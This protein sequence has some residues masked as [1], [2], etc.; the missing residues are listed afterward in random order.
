M[1]ILV[2]L[3]FLAIGL[4]LLYLGYLQQQKRRQELSSLAIQLGW[5]FDSSH[6]SSHEDR[7]PQFNIFRRGHS[8]YAY[9][10]LRG[11]FEIAEK[12]WPVVMG[13]YHYRITSGSGKNR[14][15]HTYRFSYLILELPHLRSCDLMI[16][17]EGV[18]DKL[19]GMIGFD[20]IDFESVEFSDRFHVKSSEKKFAY[21][22]LHPQMMEFLLDGNPPDIDIARRA[23]CLYTGNSC[24]SPGKFIA[25]LNW[26]DKFFRLWPRYLI[27]SLEIDSQ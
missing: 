9:H 12:S 24:W 16:R 11:Q 23:C 2:F 4:A 27:Q 6:D 14:S 7:Y 3:I 15:T 18:L 17:Q 25:I 1:Q 22:V 5:Q 26:A 20:D 8:R 13:D 21:D 10:T 19:A